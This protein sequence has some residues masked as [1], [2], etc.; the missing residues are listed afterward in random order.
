MTL[1]SFCSWT[2][3]FE[4]NRPVWVLSGRKPR[5]QLF[6]WRDL[7]LSYFQVWVRIISIFHSCE[8]QTEI[9]V[10]RVTVCHHEA[11]PNISCIPFIYVSI[12]CNKMHTV[13]RFCHYSSQVDGYAQFA[14]A[15]CCNRRYSIERRDK[16]RLLHLKNQINMCRHTRYFFAKKKKKTKKGNILLAQTAQALI[17]LRM[18]LGIQSQLTTRA[19]CRL[20]LAVAQQKYRWCLL[21]SDTKK[22][23]L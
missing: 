8:V 9:S 16:N 20:F 22:R 11:V 13:C 3:R 4:S 17:R 14:H 12:S 18:Y 15:Y 6:S 10:S 21:S 19:F 5:R 23:Y 7:L 2:D 1:A